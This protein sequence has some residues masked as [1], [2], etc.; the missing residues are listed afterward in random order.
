MNR[1]PSLILVCAL[2]CSLTACSIARQGYEDAQLQA[3][4]ASLK[5]MLSQLRDII[6]QYELDRGSP[7]GKLNDLVT[8]GYINTIPEDPITGK[9]DWI[10][11]M[12]KC[13]TSSSNC[14]EG[15]VDIRSASKSKSTQGNLYSE[16]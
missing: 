13:P 14:K 11:V 9:A 4:E 6:K 10:L 3:R 8:A 12:K 15:I 7:P 1:A 16:W 5:T 2:A